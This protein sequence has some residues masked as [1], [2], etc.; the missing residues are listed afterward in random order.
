MNDQLSEGCRECRGTAYKRLEP[1]YAVFKTE[2][3][4]ASGAMETI[5][6]VIIIIVWSAIVIWG[7]AYLVIQAKRT[8]D[9]EK[10]GI[11]AL[12][13]TTIAG[14]LLTLMPEHIFFGVHTIGLGFVLAITSAFAIFALSAPRHWFN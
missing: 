7:A 9:W 11:A 3:V 2:P 1:G 6:G 10:V 14:P 5:F 12:S 8:K 13:A 4:F